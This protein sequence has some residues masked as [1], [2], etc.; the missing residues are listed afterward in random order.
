MGARG[1]KACFQ[2]EEAFEK[3]RPSRRN[4]GGRWWDIKS[5]SESW[6]CRKLLQMRLVNGPVGVLLW[7]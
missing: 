4:D 3:L 2:G 5:L 7:R 6:W 1:R